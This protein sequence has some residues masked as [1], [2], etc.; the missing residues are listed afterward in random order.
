MNQILYVEKDKKQPSLNVNQIVRFF[1]IALIVFGVLIAGQGIY[2]VAR[3]AGISQK[4]E[5]AT[6]VVNIDRDGQYLIIKVSH[7]KPI[8]SIVYNWNDDEDVTINGN[9]RKN[10]TE[11]IE[12]PGG[13]NTFNLIARDTR[14]KETTI[15]K[16]Y[17]IDTGRDIQKPKIE[18]NIL[19][20]YAKITITDETKLSYVTYRWND[21]EEKRI[22][23]SGA[24]EAK[25]EGSIEILKGKNTLTIIA[26]DSSNN[27]TKR[28]ETF[29]GR[30]KP[31]VEV[32]ADGDAFLIIG[33]H[34]KAIDRIEYTLNGQKYKVQ[35]TAGPEMQ[36]RQKIQEGYNHISV[37]VYSVDN[38]VA[39]YEGEYTYTPE[40]R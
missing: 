32:Y 34:E 6:P 27:T 2:G 19:G 31:T 40:T 14:G 21:E 15:T 3:D 20:N 18:L 1:G 8:E 26:V 39:S 25:I 28:E 29:E 23:P 13:N 9:N 5:T 30:V 37:Q 11:R 10:I 12:L 22:E 4:F 38:T 17:S 24:E 36:Y 33:K 16:D 35:F 7:I